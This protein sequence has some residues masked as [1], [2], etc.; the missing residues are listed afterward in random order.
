[1]SKKLRRHLHKS[2]ILQPSFRGY[3]L[4]KRYRLGISVHGVGVTKGDSHKKFGKTLIDLLYPQKGRGS[5]TVLENLLIYFVQVRG[6]VYDTLQ[7]VKGVL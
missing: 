4:D 5:K 1:M 3:T 6:T 7:V 2:I